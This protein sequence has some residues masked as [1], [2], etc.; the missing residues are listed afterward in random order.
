LSERSALIM[1]AAWRGSSI[2]QARAKYRPA[3]YDNERNRVRPAPLQARPPHHGSSQSGKTLPG[4][5]RT[6]RHGSTGRQR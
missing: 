5:A 6:P 2:A 3:L 4:I 1:L